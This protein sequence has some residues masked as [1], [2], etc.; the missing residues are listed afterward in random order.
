[1]SL[2]CRVRSVLLL[3]RLRVV[4][5]VALVDAGVV[6]VGVVFEVGDD[7]GVFAADIDVRCCDC[8]CG[9]VTGDVAGAF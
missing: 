2:P 3:F 4:V 5:F 7:G 1:M 6:V 8:A 9:C